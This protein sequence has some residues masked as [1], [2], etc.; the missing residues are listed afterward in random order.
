[1]EAP[2][3]LSIQMADRAL[4]TR[5]VVASESLKRIIP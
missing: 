4:I 2:H 1:M 5:M 3:K